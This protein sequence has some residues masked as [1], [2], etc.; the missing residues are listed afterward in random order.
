MGAGYVEW[1]D[2]QR[3][4]FPTTTDQPDQDYKP[5]NLDHGIYWFLN[6]VCFGL[7]FHANHHKNAGLFNPMHLDKVLAKKAAKRHAA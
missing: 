6:R 7:Y 1:R 5:V 2:L 3:D 4:F